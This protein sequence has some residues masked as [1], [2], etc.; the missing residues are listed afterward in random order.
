MF[1]ANTGVYLPA[2]QKRRKKVEFVSCDYRN[3]LVFLYETDALL[4]THVA[5]LVKVVLKKPD[6]ILVETTN[7]VY[8]GKPV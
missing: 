2:P 5:Q 8:A 1:D 7:S 4:P 6:L 3:G